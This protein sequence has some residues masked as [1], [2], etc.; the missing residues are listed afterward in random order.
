MALR[1]SYL[2]AEKPI[3][4]LGI[5]APPPI[6]VKLPCYSGSLAQLFACV[7]EHK[8]DLLD[9]PLLPICEVYFR[10]L[11]AQESPNLDES[12][13]ALA[14][15]AFLL[16]RKAWLLLPT[17]DLPPEDPEILS[18]AECSVHEYFGVV[19]FLRQ[20][21][22]QRSQLFFRAPN[23]GPLPYEL[24]FAIESIE[25]GALAAAFAD[26][27]FRLKP[28]E[29]SQVTR[30]GRSLADEMQLLLKRL[31]D[32][33]LGFEGLLMPGST[34]EDAVYVFLSLLELMRIG[35]AQVRIAGETVEF[36]QA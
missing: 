17:A 12:A 5:V 1:K 30:L 28:P 32:A 22:E 33:W 36:S 27:L 25:V 21:F 34:R 10:Y 2:V 18:I 6:H 9:V 31:T 19:D 3:A 8:I 23:Q 26:V 15:L 11:L 20:G 35:L 24:P 29:L 16:E 14:A 13:A 7:R 4:A